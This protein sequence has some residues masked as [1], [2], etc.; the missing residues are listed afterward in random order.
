VSTAATPVPAEPLTTEQ[1]IDQ[2]AAKAASIVSLFNPAAAQAVEMGAE[3][4]PVIS[5]MVQTFISLFKHHAKQ[6]IAGQ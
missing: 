3:L 5:A 4:E 2:A 1:K 6:A